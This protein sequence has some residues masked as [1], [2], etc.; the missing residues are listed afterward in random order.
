MAKFIFDNE[1]EFEIFISNFKLLKRIDEFK[2]VFFANNQKEDFVYRHKESNLGIIYQNNQVIENQNLT[3]LLNMILNL[4][5]KP[6]L[7][8]SLSI[9]EQ[10]KKTFQIIPDFP[11][12]IYMMAKI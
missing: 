9:E 7:D 6:P 5:N 10:L 12:H 1:Q 3:Y 11:Q 2:V 4:F 8:A